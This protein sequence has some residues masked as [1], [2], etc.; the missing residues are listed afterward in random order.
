MNVKSVS[1]EEMTKAAKG[2]YY[3]ILESFLKSGE[4]FGE[5]IEIDGLAKQVGNALRTRANK[6]F[7]GKVTVTVSGDRVFLERQDEA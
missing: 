1:K 2:E 6:D 5:V 4:P 7:G 3:F